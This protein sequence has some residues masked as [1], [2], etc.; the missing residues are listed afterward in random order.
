MQ[1]MAERT[2]LIVLLVRLLILARCVLFDGL[3]DDIDGTAQ[4]IGIAHFGRLATI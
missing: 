4:E 2:G 3:L 1:S